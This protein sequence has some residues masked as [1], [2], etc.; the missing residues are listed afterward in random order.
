MRIETLD[1]N[2]RILASLYNGTL[3]LTDPLYLDYTPT[4]ASHAVNKQYVDSSLS[5]INGGNIT[6]GTFATSRLPAFTGG[7]VT[8]ATGSTIFN[9]AN[10]GV[11]LGS[12]TK[13]TVNS[14][15][16]VTGTTNISNTDIPNLD[17]SKITTGKPTTLSGYGITDAISTSGGTVTG[18]LLLSNSPTASTHAVN[19]SYIV[20]VLNSSTLIRP[21]DIIEKPY[22][23]TPSGFLKCNGAEVSK[24]TYSD[25]YAAIGDTFS[26]L[27]IPG[28]GKPWKQQYAFNT[29]Q[30]GDITGWTTESPLPSAVCASHAVVTKN[31]VYLLGG[32]SSGGYTSASTVYTAPINSDGTLG[33]WATAP[34]LPIP[35]SNAQA[36]V[37][38]SRV[39]LLGGWAGFS[40]GVVSI[41]HTAPI[42]AD[43]TLGAWSTGP[44]L[45]GVLGDSAV[46]VTKNRVYLLGGDPSGGNTSVSTVYTAPI[47]SDGTL[48]SWATAPSLPIPISNA[49]AIVTSSKVYLLGGNDNDTWLSTVYTAPINNDGTLGTWSTGT[50]LPV[51]IDYPQAIV[52]SSRVYL[53]GGRTSSGAISTIYSA[54]FSGGLNDYS[55]YYADPNN[56]KL[57][58]FTSQDILKKVYH[59]IKY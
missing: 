15:G 4:Q 32:D 3:T 43:G 10:T 11:V 24:T 33:S 36:I 52:T 48:G 50:S 34:S 18:Q 2:L 56:F 9:L 12:Y 46:V 14:K 58:D 26:D 42:N 8:S 45:P 16:L 23:T 30:S 1:S 6:T 39:Y 55:S 20:N 31:R 7:D 51:G 47:N 22:S 37:T 28:A 49:Q 57:P 38:S 17:W 35:I 59:Y 13:I 25:L 44:S 19:R 21:G 41:V 5:A 29:S 40:N 54:S 27:T 53:L